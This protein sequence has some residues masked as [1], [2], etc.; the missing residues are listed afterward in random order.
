MFQW[1]TYQQNNTPYAYFKTD[2]NKLHAGPDNNE[3]VPR[4]YYNIIMYR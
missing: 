3:Y 1:N 4:I 2:N